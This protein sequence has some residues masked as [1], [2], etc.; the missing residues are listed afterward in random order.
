LGKGRGHLDIAFKKTGRLGKITPD[1][2]NVT[3]SRSNL[4][5]KA[6]LAMPPFG[7]RFQFSSR[8]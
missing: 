3:S 2:S 6:G 7:F 1:A 4:A 5:R 8:K